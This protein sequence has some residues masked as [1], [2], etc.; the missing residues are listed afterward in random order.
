MEQTYLLSRLQLPSG[1]AVFN[2]HIFRS[3]LRYQ[4][5]KQFS[6]RIIGE[7]N[8]VLPNTGCTLTDRQIFIKL[9]YAFHF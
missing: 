9:S 1:T 6:L 4:L 7:Y 8:V 5:S 3:T 2:N